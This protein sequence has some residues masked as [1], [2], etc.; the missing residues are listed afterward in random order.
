MFHMNFEIDLPL[1][2]LD[3]TA[4]KNPTHCFHIS[5]LLRCLFIF[6]QKY[7]TKKPS[8]VQNTF[9]TSYSGKQ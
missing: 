2:L 1:V 8:D 9:F 3:L 6:N 4:Q 7:K 5:S